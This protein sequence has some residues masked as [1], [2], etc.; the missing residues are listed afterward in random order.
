MIDTGD[1]RKGVTIEM[2]GALY[3]IVDWEHIKMGR[4]GAKVRLKL[5]DVRAGHVIEQTYD[6]GAKFQR[7]RVERQ[8]AQY[9]YAEDD[10]LYFMNRETFDQ[11]AMNRDRVGD[12]SSFLKENDECSVLTYGDEAISVELPAAVVLAVAETDPW[13]KGDTAQGGTKPAKLETGLLVQ[14]PLFVNTGDKVKV[15][16]RSGEYLERAS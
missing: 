5:R 13:V 15:D 2:D 4:G 14:V 12:L 9:L 10:I 6:A 8:P 3:N 1:L 7:A 11:I 16:T